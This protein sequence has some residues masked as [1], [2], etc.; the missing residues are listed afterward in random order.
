MKKSFSFTLLLLLVTAA[1]D[2]QYNFGFEEYS[3]SGKLKLWH[4]QYD[5]KQPLIVPD[6]EIKHSGN[7]SLSIERRPGDT[8]SQFTARAV[9]IPVD[10]NGDKIKIS[11]W[12][13]TENVSAYAQLWLRQDDDKGRLLILANYPRTSLKGTTGWTRYDTTLILHERASVIYFGF[14]IVGSG[15][16]WCD[17]LDIEVDGKPLQNI[18]RGNR[19]MAP[20]LKDNSEFEKGSGIQVTH[21]APQQVENLALLGKVWG[22]LKYYHPYIAQGNLNWDYELFRFLPAYLAVKS[23]EERNALLLQWTKKL[24]GPA[25]CEQCSDKDL[26]NAIRLP[27]LDW[28][29]DTK[30]LGDSLSAALVYIRDNRHR[31]PGFYMDQV[32]G[33]RNPRILHEE[34]Y[35]DMKSP[36][37]GYRLLTLFRYWNMIQYWFPYKHLIGEDWK[38]VLTEFIPKML[39]A[40]DKVKYFITTR[41]LIARIHD[42][43]ANTWG[44]SSVR[45][46][47]QGKY[48]APVK[49]QFVNDTAVVSVIME[50]SLASASGL[51]KGDIILAI[52]GKPVA[53][54]INNA[55]PDLPASNRP[56]QLRDLAGLLLRSNDSVST[57]TI[58]RNDRQFTTTLIRGTRKQIPMKFY[59]DFPYQK[60]SS[61]FFIRPGIGYIN[62]GTIKR[63]SVD[64]VFRALQGAKGLIID[65]RQYPGDFPISEISEKLMPKLTGFVQFPSGS[66][67]Y[68]GAFIEYP[69]I[70]VGKRNPDYFKGKVVI[71]V[72]EQTQSSGEYHSMAFR[73]AP[74]AI[75]IGSTTAGAD[76][77]VST[78]YLPGGIFTMFSGIGVNYPDGRET[79]RVGIVP[80]VTV[81]RTIEGIRQGRDELVE[82]AVELI[83]QN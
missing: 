50:P 3:D 4:T 80:D 36:D 69:P 49:I 18:E 75:V 35:F 39:E 58:R 82:K 14:L 68:P 76:G 63:S 12:L 56:T 5:P 65:N 72:N 29:G 42:T 52:D 45:D 73:A 70:Q 83:S 62:L 7:L 9:T 66:L 38:N 13:K 31:G 60:D 40:D 41:R 10:F 25:P 28:L 23:K 2:A 81:W 48:F 57:L 47:L 51:E 1:S 53:D 27:D 20:A 34:P 74:G 17:D 55:L 24:K 78:F 64:S 22:F 46:S 19:V 6:A 77:N 16:V 71:L 37:A 43:H 11:G 32:P 59:P 61:F 33:V 44:A 26:K 21:P 79:Q 67:D 8:A 15:K 30:E 54:I